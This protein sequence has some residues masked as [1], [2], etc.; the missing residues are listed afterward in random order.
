MWKKIAIIAGSGGVGLLVARS[1]TDSIPIQLGGAG[2][3]IG[4]GYMI[5]LFLFVDTSLPA[6]SSTAS[7]S[8][9]TSTSSGALS[10]RGEELTLTDWMNY[11]RFEKIA[12]AESLG[13]TEIEVEAS[14]TGKTVAE[15]EQERILQEAKDMM[16][17]GE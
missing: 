10:V 11:T 15:I 9:P 2:L 5:D 1:Q 16:T 14:L 4:I 6:P 17:W 3:G 12:V 7:T 8:T 13:K